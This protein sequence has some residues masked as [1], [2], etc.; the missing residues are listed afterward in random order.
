MQISQND[1]ADLLYPLII[2]STKEWVKL[3]QVSKRFNIKSKQFLIK[4]SGILKDWVELPCG[5]KH[6]ILRKWYSTGRLKSEFNYV[7]NLKHGPAQ[8]WYRSGQ[9]DS[10]QKWQFGYLVQI[11]FI[12][13]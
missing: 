10:I 9:L 8:A 5:Y 7:Y 3:S 12:F 2:N 13:K 6:G 11:E 1:L 4:K